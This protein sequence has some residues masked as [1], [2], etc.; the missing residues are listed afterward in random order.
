MWR[1]GEYKFEE[2]GRCGENVNISLKK[3]VDVERR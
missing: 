3:R 2:E 1:E